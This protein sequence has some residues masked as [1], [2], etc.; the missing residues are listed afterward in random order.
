[1]HA[2]LSALQ[3]IVVA[4]PQP[5]WLD[6]LVRY[7]QDTSAT[8]ITF[9]YDVLVEVAW[10]QI[11]GDVWWYL[12]SVPMTPAASRAGTVW[13]GDLPETGLKLLKLHGSLNWYYSGITSPPGDVLYDL[14]VGGGWQVGGADAR[15]DSSLVADREPC[16]V[17]PAATKSPYYGNRT[18]H[19]LWQQ[20]AQALRDAD[21]VVVMGFSLPP[22]DQ[23]VSAMLASELRDDCIVT[24]IDRSS[25]VVERFR[26]LLDLP[27]PTSRVRGEFVGRP[28]VIREWVKN[29]PP[30]AG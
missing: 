23:L 4:E 19:A 3:Y 11:Y 28:D 26:A 16:I 29:L 7:W 24:P 18:L 25:E 30:S 22:S 8:V 21:E 14:G 9:N 1:V 15:Y 20:A 12:Y 10:I 6:P 27:G 17:P 13:G 5:D 2:A